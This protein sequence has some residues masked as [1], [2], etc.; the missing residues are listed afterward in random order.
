MS[1]NDPLIRAEGLTKHYP[2]EDGFFDRVSLSQGGS[3]GWNFDGLLKRQNLETSLLVQAAGQSMLRVGADWSEERFRGEYFGDMLGLGTYF[4]S[5]FSD[6]VGFTLSYNIGEDIFRADPQ[7]GVAQSAS[8]SLSLK[9]VQNV[10][11][12]PSITY[13][14]MDDRQDNELYAGYITRA[15]VNYQF[16][17]E[18]FLRVV[19]EWNDFSQ[20]LSV[21]PLLL[22]RLNPFSVLYLGSTHGYAEFDDP[23]GMERTGRQFFLKLQ[24]LFRP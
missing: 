14:R 19:T 7:I 17:R 24:Y 15:R 13:A 3:A 23:F 12:N 4:R 21:E 20:Q 5:N 9:P 22:Y 18:L 8:A 6:A 2:S 11:I 16:S 10:V 1:S